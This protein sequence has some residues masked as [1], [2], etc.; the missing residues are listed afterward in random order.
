MQEILTRK[1]HRVLFYKMYKLREMLIEYYA[2]YRLTNRI[3]TRA[4]N[5]RKTCKALPSLITVNG[6][7]DND[8]IRRCETPGTYTHIHSIEHRV[9]YGILSLY[10]LPVS[11]QV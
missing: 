5:S 3:L 4:T 8:A 11:R 7:W 2:D 10:F 1:F 9:S 6:Q